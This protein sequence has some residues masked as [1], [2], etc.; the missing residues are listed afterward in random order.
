[1]AEADIL[2]TGS[3][4]WYGPV[5]EAFPDETSIAWNAAWGGNWVYAGPLA[6]PLTL[7]YSE[8]RTD[9]EQQDALSSVKDWRTDERHMLR[10]ELREVTGTGLALLMGATNTD[11]A[12]GGSQ[13]AYSRIVGGGEAI[14]TQYA[15]GFEG[16]RPDSD[17]T[18]QPIRLLYYKSS[19]MFDRGFTKSKDG[20]PLS[21][22]FMVKTFSDPSKAIGQQLF[23]WHIVTGPTT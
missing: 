10:S 7:S 13:K 12:A 15:V 5:G 9:A 18:R 21:L 11:T 6:V 19:F 23:E 14:V 20:A 8:T 4:V 2:L 3:K 22:P 17:G 16:W 1:M